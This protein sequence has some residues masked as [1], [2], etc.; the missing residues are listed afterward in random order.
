VAIERTDA[1]LDQINALSQAASRP[2]ALNA[3]RKARREAEREAQ[4]EA[5]E[6]QAQEDRL[7]PL[8]NEVQNEI[9]KF[10]RGNLDNARQ[11]AGQDM[12]RQ[13]ISQVATNYLRRQGNLTPEQIR[14]FREQDFKTLL[15][16]YGERAYLP[17]VGLNAAPAPADAPNS[18]ISNPLTIAN[19][20]VAGGP[21]QADGDDV[22][23]TDVASNALSGLLSGFGGLVTSAGCPV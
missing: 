3:E 16:R 6:A 12:R 4:R 18:S 7:R 9:N 15:S 10:F 1:F 13:I 22:S 21:A 17:D 23:F 2:D 20:A 8:A 5:L 11:E 14:E 19:A